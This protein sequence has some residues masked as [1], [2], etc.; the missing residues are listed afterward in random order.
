MEYHGRTALITGAS[1]GIGAQFAKTLAAKGTNVILV[2]RNE[3][4]LK[5]LA[6]QLQDQHGIRAEYIAQDLSSV[7]AADGLIAEVDRRA[8]DV[9]ILINNAGFAIHAD[10]VDSDPMRIR[11]QVRLNVGLLTDLTTVYLKRMT[12]KGSGAIVNVSSVAAFQPVPHLA[13]Y[14]A[15]KA[16]VLSFSES[17]W[18]ESRRRG[19]KVLAVCPGATDTGF[20]EVAGAD[21]DAVG[22]RRTTQQVVDTALRGLETGK[23]S[24]VDGLLN[25]IGTTISRI[26][27]HRLVIAAAELAVRQSLRTLKN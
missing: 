5:E 13:V 20:F 2:A 18:W 22:P 21:R 4:A 1:A 23:P 10:L 12:D 7:N 3:V 17:L 24:V 26:A 14:A 11:D 27:P 8:L 19:V 15:S 6:M 16:Y 9:D 25:V